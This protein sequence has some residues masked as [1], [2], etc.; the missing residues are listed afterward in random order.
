L[1][2]SWRYVRLVRDL[3]N[4]GTGF[5][6]PSRSA[7]GIALVLALVGAAM[8]AAVISVSKLRE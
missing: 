8:A 6:H 5:R 3:N 2:F 7:I 1:S 4:G